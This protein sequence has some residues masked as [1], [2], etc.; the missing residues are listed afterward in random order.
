MTPFVLTILM[1]HYVRDPGDQAE[2]GSGIAGMPVKDFGT[3]VEHLAKSHAMIA[4]PELQTHLRDGSPLPPDAC[5]LT[6]DDGMRDHYLNVMPMLRSRGLSGLFFTIARRPEDGLVL[7]HKIHYLLAKLG[8]DTLRAEFLAQLSAEQRG[9][10]RAAE[11]KYGVRYAGLNLFKAVLQRDLSN[12]A[13]GILSAMIEQHI[14]PEEEI[15]RGY[16]LTPEQMA[17]MKAAG[18]YFGGH[19]HSH[20]WLDWISAEGRAAEIKAS[21]D[22]LNGLED[23]PWAFAYPYGGLTDD[24]PQHLRANQ[25]IAGFTTK[26]RIAHRDP[27]Y[28][29]RLDGEEIA[30]TLDNLAAVIG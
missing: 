26:N 30:P 17:E 8:L 12:E 24:L 14:G 25:F 18:M 11:H 16:Y 10:F 9:H 7:G 3:Q 4:W 27:A 2:G 20:P 6:F 19:S 28:L 15:A 5:L 22:R 23:G 1:Y 13:E 21:A 29:G